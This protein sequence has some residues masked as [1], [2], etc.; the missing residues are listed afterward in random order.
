M[1]GM[2]DDHEQRSRKTP[3]RR[4]SIRDLNGRLFQEA[5]ESGELIGVT[6]DRRLTAVLLPV[7]PDWVD[8]IV[9]DHFSRLLRSIEQ[10]QKVVTAGKPLLG[11][12]DITTSGK[13]SLPITRRVAIRDLKGPVLREAAENGE[14]LGVLN[15]G[16]LCAVLVPVTPEW[17]DQ[18]V[19]Y[20]I[21]RLIQSVEVG[22]KSVADDS[23]R[24]S[25]DAV[26][27]SEPWQ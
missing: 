11:W 26:P 21:S 12:E 24:H 9:E 4:V 23:P 15:D 5:A 16:R 22:Q 20:N 7:T 3:L 10:G 13:Q 14:L 19:D 6:N 2:A 8:R 27:V 1:V 17:I 25:F 18:L